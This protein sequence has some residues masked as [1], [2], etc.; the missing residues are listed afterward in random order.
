M[1]F[2]KISD[3]KILELLDVMKAEDLESITTGD[4]FIRKFIDSE[5]EGFEVIRIAERRFYDN[6]CN[7]FYHNV[8]ENYAPTVS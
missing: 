3:K 5:F 7:L 4:V 6:T 8:N 1:T 2:A